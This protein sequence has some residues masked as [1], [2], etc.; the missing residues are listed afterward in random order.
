MESLPYGGSTCNKQ[1]S[2]LSKV[3]YTNF[4]TELY[5]DSAGSIHLGLG[6]AYRDRYLVA[7]WPLCFFKKH[8]P[9]IALLELIAVVVAIETWVP[10]MA[11]SQI[12]L[13]SDNES[14][15]TFIEKSTSK[16]SWCMALLRRL[17]LVC[18]HFQIHVKPIHI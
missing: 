15:I 10:L 3:S 9:S 7:C 8:T 11:G 13:R 1:R 5:T 6:A 18:L 2:A 17:T 4:G 12:I 16:C 14:V